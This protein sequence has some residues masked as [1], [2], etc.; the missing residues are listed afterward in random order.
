[1]VLGSLAVEVQLEAN[2]PELGGEVVLDFLP[3]ELA[4]PGEQRMNQERG[5]TTLPLFR[6]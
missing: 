4:Q 1:M 5:S 3:A 6:S 2:L